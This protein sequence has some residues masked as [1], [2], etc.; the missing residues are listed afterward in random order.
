MEI[1]EDL[2]ISYLLGE[3]SAEEAIQVEE[4]RSED[5]AYEAKYEQFRLIWETSRKLQF[6]G[7]SDAAASLKVLKQKAAEQKLQQDKSSTLHHRYLWLKIAAA[8]LILI[9]G[10][11]LYMAQRTIPE[12][13]LSTQ[14]AVKTD[15]LSDGS[16]VTLN[17]KTVIMYP[18]KFS[19]HQRNIA[20]EKGEAFFSITPDKA[21]PFIIHTEGITIQ[22]V[23]T[24]FNV[25]NRM[26]NV[27][28][29]VEAGTVH[30]SMNGRLVV[31]EPGE[32]VT[33]RYNTGKLIKEDTPDQLYT[34]YRTREFVADNTPLWRMVE[35]L[36][37]A[38]DSHIVI[39]KKELGNLPL[40]TTFKNESLDDILHIISRTFKITAEK[41]HDQIIL[42]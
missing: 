1:N 31:L 28:V 3:V 22:V 8:V 39:G 24:S 13:E 14:T 26:G 19:D 35:V 33:V 25:K 41:K 2:L 42:Q 30:V 37:E 18:E 20:L 12:I 23:G 17:K 16:V 5:I 32:K 7:Q 29:I 15:T 38:Y 4:W 9:G 34:Y 10:T 21:R 40:N 27:E 36:N 11:W 6:E